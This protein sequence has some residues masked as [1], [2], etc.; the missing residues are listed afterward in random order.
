MSRERKMRW[1]G[2]RYTKN[3]RGEASADGTR[4]STITVLARRALGLCRR[5]GVGLIIH[6]RRLTI[7]RAYTITI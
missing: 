2:K 6:H 4:L 1:S 3:V 5:M 7:L